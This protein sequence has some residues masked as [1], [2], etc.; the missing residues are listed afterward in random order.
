MAWYPS[1]F[2]SH[3]EGFMTRIRTV[4]VVATALLMAAPAF[5]QRGGGGGGS[6]STKDKVAA[7]RGDAIVNGKVTDDAGKAIDQA[8][9]TWIFVQAND[10]FFATTK[11]SGEYSANDIKAGQWRVQVD[12]PN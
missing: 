10:G 12:A 9:V 1:P 2:F 8:K 6:R 11:K 4:T 5:A 3:A 7:W